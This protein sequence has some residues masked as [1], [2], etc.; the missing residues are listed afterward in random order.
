VSSGMNGN[1][2]WFDVFWLSQDREYQ[3]VVRDG[4][5]RAGRDWDYSWK[6]GHTNPFGSL[7]V[8]GSDQKGMSSSI[9]RDRPLL[10]SG[11][12]HLPVA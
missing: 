11:E 12:D 5:R 4:P 1:I 7:P 8:F 9:C 3:T 10:P 2:W 6:L